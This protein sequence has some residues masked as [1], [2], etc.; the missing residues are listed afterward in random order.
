VVDLGDRGAER[1]EPGALPQ[2]LPHCLL[3]RR[4]LFLGDADL[5]ASAARDN[6]PRRVFGVVAE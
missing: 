1:G 5:V 2:R 6:D 4:Q 3:H